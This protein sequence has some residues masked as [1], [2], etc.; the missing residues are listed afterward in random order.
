MRLWNS[1]S[2]RGQV[3][4]LALLLTTVLVHYAVG[5]VN[6]S[7]LLAR[8]GGGFVRANDKDQLLLN[9]AHVVRLTLMP[10]EGEGEYGEDGFGYRY[11]LDQGKLMR[12]DQVLVQVDHEPHWPRVLG[13]WVAGPGNQFYIKDYPYVN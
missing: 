13:Y 8:S 2:S 12:L 9:V 10:G 11:A 6:F 7:L 4:L 3:S 5:Q 1:R